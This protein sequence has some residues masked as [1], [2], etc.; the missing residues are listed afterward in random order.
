[1]VDKMRERDNPSK[2]FTS[3]NQSNK[4]RYHYYDATNTDDLRMQEDMLN[5]IALAAINNVDNLY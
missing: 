3:T 4:E 5:P 2:V 1:M